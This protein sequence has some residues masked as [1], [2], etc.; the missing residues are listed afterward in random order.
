MKKVIRNLLMVLIIGLL[1]NQCKKENV[2][3]GQSETGKLQIT[4]GLKVTVGEVG[5]FLK[6]TADVEDFTV[7]IYKDDGTEVISYVNYSDVPAEIDLDPGDY[8]VVAH[9]GNW[10]VAAFENPYYYGQSENFTITPGESQA[11]SVNCELANCMVTIVYS[12]NVTDNFSDYS[13]TVSSDEGSLTFVKDETRAGYFDPGPLSIEATLEYETTGG[14]TITK[15]LTGSIDNPLAKKHYEIHVDAT[16]DQGSAGLT[17]NLDESV[18]D[19][20]V[21]ISDDSEPIVEGPIGYG[22]LLITEIMYDPTA[23]TDNYGEWFEIYNN[24]GESVDLQNVVIKRNGEA[25]HTINS[26]VVLNAGAY[27]LLE[28]T[29]D[30]VDGTDLIT[31]VYGSALSLLND[32][33]TLE[34]ANYGSNGTNGS[35][36]ASVTYGS[37]NN[38]PTASGASIQL[39]PSHFDAD[40]AQAG[41]NWCVSTTAYNTGD[42]GT[43]GTANDPCQ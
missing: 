17:I 36:I 30:A 6:S 33:C 3:P 32:A 24:S 25:V 40:E 38:F 28:R 42:M 5:G 34:I 39:D 26:S 43:P 10:S 29:A 16:V 31:Y 35:V 7:V 8:Y 11:V 23:I 20:V 19:E 4:I 41:T 27:C 15:T 14:T 12:Q 13:T 2:K 21:E 37:G 9:S 18:D 22:D 1:F